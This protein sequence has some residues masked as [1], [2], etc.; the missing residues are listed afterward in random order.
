[1]KLPPEQ[2]P[3]EDGVTNEEEI[4]HEKEAKLTASLSISAEN[5]WY[6]NLLSSYTRTVRIT[7]CMVRVCSNIKKKLNERHVSEL[8]VNEIQS[9]KRILI[10]LI[11]EEAFQEE[12]DPSLKV[13]CTFRDADGLLR[14]KTKIMESIEDVLCFF[15]ANTN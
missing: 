14:L 7:A 11:K 12:R 2:W 15:Q 4:Y 6:L 10:K 3:S 8:F 9:Y 13:L 1:M 5:W